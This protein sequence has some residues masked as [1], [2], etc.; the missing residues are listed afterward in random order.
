VDTLK[1]LALLQ[2]IFQQVK[3]FPAGF[4]MAHLWQ[5]SLDLATASRGIAKAEGL[6]RG[7]QSDCFT[8]GL[9]HDVGLMILA[10]GFPDAYVEIGG[11]LHREPVELLSAE[12]RILGVHH[13]EV[14]AYLLGLWGLP[15]AVVEA[16]AHHH[17]LPHVGG[18]TVS[19]ALVV[20]AAEALSAPHGDCGVFS[21]R[22]EV[23]L[24]FLSVALGARL[25][26]WKSAMDQSREAGG[27]S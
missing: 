21:L 6:D 9:I 18:G 19:P 14:G 16:V 13:G 8:G 7:L 5:H 12:M 2:G 24:Q 23:D 15:E 26:V 17:S 1:S 3:G 11:L 10:A 20:H 27:A 25:D 22:R 4:N